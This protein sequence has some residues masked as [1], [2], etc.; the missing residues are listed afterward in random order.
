MGPYEL[1]A[2]LEVVLTSSKS[3]VSTGDGDLLVD[4]TGRCVGACRDVV[5]CDCA[6]P[7]VVVVVG[8]PS[9]LVVLCGV[10]CTVNWSIDSN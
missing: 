8:E 6:K 7:A 10:P 9:G 1:L 2:D 5:R 4:V 3:I